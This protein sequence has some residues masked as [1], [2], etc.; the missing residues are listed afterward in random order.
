MGGGL[1]TVSSKNIN[2]RFEPFVS[3]YVSAGL[4]IPILKNTLLQTGLE[5]EQK[6][7]NGELQGYIDMATD[8]FTSKRR[9]HYLTVPLIVS[10]NAFKTKHSKIWLGAGMNYGFF[11]KGTVRNIS[12]EYDNNQMLS[13]KVYTAKVG[14][15]WTT[16]QFLASTAHADQVYKMDV[17]TRLQL[18]YEL[19]D[20]YSISLFYDRSLYDVHAWP[21][22]D[23]G[24]SIKSHYL[25]MAAAIEFR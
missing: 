3:P 22:G 5:Y 25:G 12:Y 15:I 10:Y 18:R 13:R 2:E 19:R 1:V 8:R 20:K 11:L 4:Y 16:S 24:S 17:M 14:S 9:Y 21:V 7:F 6:G 23:V